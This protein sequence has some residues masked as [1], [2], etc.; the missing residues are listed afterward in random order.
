MR[1]ENKREREKKRASESLIRVEWS[2]VEWSAG[3]FND[4]REICLWFGW[5]FYFIIFFLSVAFAHFKDRKAHR[6][7]M[8]PLFIYY[9]YNSK[10]LLCFLF[11]E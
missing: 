9:F 3:V 1:S 10:C 2:G 4:D 5:I 8:R 7:K 11:Y 6:F